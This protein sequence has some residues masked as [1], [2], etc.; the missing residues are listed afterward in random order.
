MHAPAPH[1]SRRSLPAPSHRPRTALAQEGLCAE[2]VPLVRIDG[3]TAHARR[4]YC[5]DQFQRDPALRVALLSIG[6]CSAG[7]T[8]TAASVV[9]FAELSWNATELQQAEARAHRIGQTRPVHV[10]YCVAPH[11]VDEIIWRTVQN[12]VLVTAQVTGTSGSQQQFR[13]G[14]DA[15]ASGGG[16]I[17]SFMGR[18]AR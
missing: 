11:T 14:S 12:K 7:V 15:T 3:S 17:R 8:L 1:T 18:Q 5:I 9:V 16:D 6:S 4:D 2:R 13:M 10:H